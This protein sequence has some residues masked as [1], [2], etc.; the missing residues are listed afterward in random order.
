MIR[1]SPTGTRLGERPK[2]PHQKPPADYRMSQKAMGF[3]NYFNLLLHAH[4]V[5]DVTQTKM[6]I[7]EPLVFQPDFIQI[8]LVTEKA[9]IIGHRSDSVEFI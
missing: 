7:A 9:Q 2:T 6:H 5:N 8:E 1:G 3:K 4:G